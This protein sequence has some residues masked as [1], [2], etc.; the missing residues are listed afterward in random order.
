MSEKTEKPTGK[1]INELRSEGNI[2]KSNELNAAVALLLSAWIFSGT[3]AKLI[4]D[5]KAL[6]TQ[7]M[8][9]LPNSESIIEWLMALLSDEGVNVALDV[10][11][12]LIIFL[13]T[14]VTITLLQTRFLWAKKRI[15]FKF[16][17]LNPLNGLKNIFSINGVVEFIKAFLKVLVVGWVAYGFLSSRVTSLIGLAQTDF[18]SGLE[19][20]AGLA[21]SLTYRIGMAY[22]VIAIIDYSYQRW[23]YDKN[24]KMTKEEVKEEMK[25]REGDPMIKNRIRGQQRRMAR[26]RMMSN[27][28]KADVIIT[29]PT[30]LAIAIQYDQN[31]MN[32]PKILAKGAF[33][34]AE[35]IVNIARASNIPIIQN[36]P[37]AHAIYK[38]VN[39]DQEI[40]PELYVAM[41]EVLARIYSLRNKKPIPATAL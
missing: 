39:I 9:T 31:S 7:T 40:P 13:T 23:Q 35:R 2:A 21:I 41:A 8:V 25:Q 12:I 28:H 32:A 30:H 19:Y 3:G 24:T 22:V 26:I 36:I 27:V 29:N 4:S 1:R 15:G 34:M 10:A 5:L 6:I 33:L 17:K 20:W 37:L 38:S 14:G 16:S 18:I 11:I